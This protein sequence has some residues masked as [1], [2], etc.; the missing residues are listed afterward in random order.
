GALQGHVQLALPA[1]VP[2]GPG[3]GACL[4][5][6]SPARPRAAA[7]SPAPGS[8]CAGAPSRGVSLART[9]KLLLGVAGGGFVLGAMR[10]QKAEAYHFCGHIYTTGSWPPP[11]RPPPSRAHRLP[12]RA[13]G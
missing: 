12:P 6:T 7:S 1:R 11:T 10:A 8:C 4:A 13:G 9:G 2:A 3:G 5:S